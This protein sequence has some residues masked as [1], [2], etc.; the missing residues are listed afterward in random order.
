MPR[1]SGAENY[2]ETRKTGE[3]TKTLT[4]ASPV[5]VELWRGLTAIDTSQAGGGNDIRMDTLVWWWN[6]GPQF[7]PVDAHHGPG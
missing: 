1:L 5:Q 3:P 4:A 6:T 2:G 7:K